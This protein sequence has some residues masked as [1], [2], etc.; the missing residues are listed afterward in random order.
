[1]R[2]YFDYNRGYGD[3]VLNNVIECALELARSTYEGKKAA[4]YEDKNKEVLKGIA[5]YA[6]TGTPSEAR[7]EA[8]GLACLKSP[9]VRNNS[10]FRDQFNA[11]LAQVVTAIVPEVVNEDFERYIAEIK[12]VGYGDTARFQIESNDLFKVNEKA[13]GVRRGVDQPMYDT[14]FTVN[15]HPI[16]ISTHIDWYPY[17]SGTFDMGNFALKIARSFEAYI[18]LK[19]IKGM[20]SASSNFGA[21]YGAN[22]VTPTLWGTLKQRVSAANGGMNVIAIGTEIALSNVSLQ[23]NFQVQIGEEMNKVGY[24]DQYLGVPI[25]AL[26]NV[27]VPG[28][29]NGSATLA[30]AD[31]K[32]YFVPVAG[33]KPVKI[34]FEGNEVA[35]EYDPAHTSDTRMGITVT[36]RVGISAICGAKYGTIT[37]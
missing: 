11:V 21:A 20:A 16:E 28:T 15:A 7:F 13:E 26:K 8:D 31:N 19:A 29:T 30:L 34:V 12:Q 35:V 36:M 6:V 5:K 22:G 33:D 14:E 3:D 18:F 37:L 4:D 1:M 32:I 24:L 2:K 27:L 25:I 23:G 17:A 10:T 9:M